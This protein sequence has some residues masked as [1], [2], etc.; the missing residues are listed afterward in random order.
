MPQDPVVTL[1]IDCLTTS[2]TNFYLP[3]VAGGSASPSLEPFTAED[4]DLAT[5]TVTSITPG[6]RLTN[7]RMAGMT[8]CQVAKT[9]WQ[10]AVNVSGNTLFAETIRRVVN[11]SGVQQK[12]PDRINQALNGCAAL[13]VVSSAA[14]QAPRNAVASIGR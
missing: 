7:A 14:T 2:G 11:I 6:M 5:Q 9:D 3:A 13:A 12:L 8:N 10:L 4:L 1:L